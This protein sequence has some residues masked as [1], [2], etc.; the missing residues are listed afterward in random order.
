MKLSFKELLM[1]KDKAGD[2]AI[3]QT[4]YVEHCKSGS[5]NNKCGVT[6]KDDATLIHCFHC[7]A[8]GVIKDKYAK[9][10]SKLSNNS[11]KRHI[12]T[13]NSPPPDAKENP[14]QWSIE[15]L[16]W[17]GHGGLTLTEA[18]NYHM[19]YSR[20]AGRLFIP[21]LNEG[22]IVGWLARKIEAEGEKYLLSK[23]DDFIFN[24]D[25]G[26][27]TCIIVEDCLS[28]IRIG[29]SF[30]V[31]ALM[32]TAL[33]SYVLN[34]LINRYKSYIIWLDNDNPTVKMKQ[35]KARNTLSSFGD[36][37]M[38]K[39]AKDPKEYTDLELNNLI[40]GK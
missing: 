27:D 13:F 26:S 40:K 6:R 1:L 22:E 8:K 34:K 17:I 12:K 23:K 36:V 15:A 11:S 30:D 28:A 25:N 38:L 4:A 29:R 37:S 39:T 33:S 18:K 21:L 14:S 19:R 2:L 20:E 16:A 32:G 3:D 35:V 24:I 31:V 5:G 9:V 7:G 10:N